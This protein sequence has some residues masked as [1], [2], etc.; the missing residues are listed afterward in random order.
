MNK[1]Y[2]Y[3]AI[4]I[5]THENESSKLAACNLFATSDD[6]AKQMAHEKAVETFPQ[7]VGF[8]GY[9]IHVFQVIP[10][11]VLR[12]AMKMAGGVSSVAGGES[13]ADDDSVLNE[14]IINI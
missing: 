1:E 3:T 9:C 4:I 10:L 11:E 14:S 5:A 12:R 2:L 13:S 8:N 6:E 7:S